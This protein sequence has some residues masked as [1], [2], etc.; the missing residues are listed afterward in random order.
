MV[1]GHTQL[2]HS[3]PFCANQWAKIVHENVVQHRMPLFKLVVSLFLNTA[4]ILG[5]TALKYLPVNYT[6][7]AVEL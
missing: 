7:T 3:T 5:A 6:L 2:T 1:P 4:G